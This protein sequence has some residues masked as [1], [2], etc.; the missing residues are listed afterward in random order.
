MEDDAAIGA[1]SKAPAKDDPPA[2]AA[3]PFIQALGIIA[4]LVLAAIDAFGPPD[5]SPPREL[6]ALLG[7]AI[8]GLG[9]D[10]L[11]QLVKAWR[12]V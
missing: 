3:I 9:P 7:A 12:K 11:V 10:Q 1:H 4:T 8:V 5:F 2:P 6:Y